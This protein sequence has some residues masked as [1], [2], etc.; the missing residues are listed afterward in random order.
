MLSLMLPD[1]HALFAQ[2]ETV[3]NEATGAV[4]TGATTQL[5]FKMCNAILNMTKDA[6]RDAVLPAERIFSSKFRLRRD[7]F[8]HPVL[9][10]KRMET[11]K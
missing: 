9:L 10:K 11:F 5:E 4:N 7:D 2:Y 3:R 1:G 8:V 6:G